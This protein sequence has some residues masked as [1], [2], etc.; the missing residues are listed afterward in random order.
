VPHRRPKEELREFFRRWQRL[1][2]A[3]SGAVCAG[4][5]PVGGAKSN[6]YANRLLLVMCNL[7]WANV[8]NASHSPGLA[9]PR[10]RRA[11]CLLT[12]APWRATT[13]NTVY[14]LRT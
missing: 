1:A 2:E 14:A 4:S 5:N 9:R 3:L 7:T 10:S 6:T 13:I 8:W 12:S 11:R